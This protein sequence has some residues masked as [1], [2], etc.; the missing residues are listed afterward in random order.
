MLQGNYLDN[1]TREGFRI[2][3]ETS[4]YSFAAVGKAAIPLLSSNS[5]LLT[6]SYIGAI[7]AMPGYNIMGVAKA[8]LESNIEYMASNLGPYGVRVNGISAGPIKTLAASGVKDLK[9]FLTF[10]E[11]SAPLRRNVTI[12]DVGNTAAILCS[13]FSLRNYR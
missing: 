4:C 1:L 7:R 3:H 10:V 9:K 5:A 6:L 2:A 13:R 8:S 12:E 11:E